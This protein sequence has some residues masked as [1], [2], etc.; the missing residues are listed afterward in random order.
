MAHP[1]VSRYLLY[2]T[3]LSIHFRHVYYECPL[4]MLQQEQKFHGN[5][6]MSF[7]VAKTIHLPAGCW[8]VMAS[9]GK[10][11]KLNIFTKCNGKCKGILRIGG[12]VFT[13]LVALNTIWSQL[14]FLLLVSGQLI[15]A[16]QKRLTNLVTYVFIM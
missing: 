7:L 12:N 15:G 14:F 6:K 16:S 3:M 5:I 2:S 13:L 1:V 11:N 9:C 8:P 10:R 4:C